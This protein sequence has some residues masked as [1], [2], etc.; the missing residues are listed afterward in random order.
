[1][2]ELNSWTGYDEVLRGFHEAASAYGWLMKTPE[3]LINETLI[4][5]KKKSRIDLVRA[6]AVLKESGFVKRADYYVSDDYGQGLELYV[7]NDELGFSLSAGAEI[8]KKFSDVLSGMEEL[9][10]KIIK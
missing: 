6:G 7:F 8:K 10:K 4:Y 5:V 2:S 1:M 9:I 3:E